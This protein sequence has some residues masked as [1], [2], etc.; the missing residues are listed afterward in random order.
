LRAGRARAS[1]SGPWGGSDEGA[2]GAT[3]R[4]LE[5]EVTRRGLEVMNGTVRE[6]VGEDHFTLLP[7]LLGLELSCGCPSRNR[8]ALVLIETAWGGRPG[9]VLGGCAALVES[10][11]P[12]CTGGRTPVAGPLCRRFP[13][14][15]A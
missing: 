1:G 12:A 13:V 3:R 9:G 11:D 6:M 8:G 14:L 2:F 4:A 5:P 10:D 7:Q 15:A